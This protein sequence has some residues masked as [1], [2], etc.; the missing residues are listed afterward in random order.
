MTKAHRRTFLEA[1]FSDIADE[2]RWGLVS[3]LE[4]RI[5]RV[6]TQWGG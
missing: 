4:D 5:T 6:N 3:M 1:L 2:K